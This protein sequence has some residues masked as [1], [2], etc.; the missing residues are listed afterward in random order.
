ME[1]KLQSKEKSL[2][3]GIKKNQDNKRVNG[4]HLLDLMR[5]GVVSESVSQ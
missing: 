4:G 3:G 1:T 5:F 2:I